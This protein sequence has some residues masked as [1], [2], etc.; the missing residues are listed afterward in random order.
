MTV[1]SDFTGMLSPEEGALSCIL[2]SKP[3]VGH[4][5]VQSRGQQAL[6]VMLSPGSGYLDSV[7][8]LQ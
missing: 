5:R 7:T 8:L 4:G 6:G 1:L 3:T 2:G